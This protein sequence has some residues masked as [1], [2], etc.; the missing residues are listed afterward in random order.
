MRVSNVQSEKN[1][2]EILE[3]AGR[4]FRKRGFDGVGV[5]DLMKA[6]G[7]THGGF[8]NHFSGKDEL[9]R[10]AV[11]SALTQANAGLK[12]EIAAGKWKQYVREYLTR[13]HRDG[14]DT[15][16]TLAALAPDAA[17]KDAKLQGCFAHAIEEVVSAL[18]GHIHKES[19]VKKSRAREQALQML[20]ELVGALVL[21]RAVARGNPELSAELLTASRHKL[22]V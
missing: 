10:E 22:A 13:E 9:E 3:T 19:A 21:S 16:C 14:P 4:L 2:Q 12:D 17:R 5:A 18:A 1:K 15:G 11:K 20:S 6:A 8:Y 7:F